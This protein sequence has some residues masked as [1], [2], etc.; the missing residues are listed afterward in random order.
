MYALGLTGVIGGSYV[1]AGGAFALDDLMPIAVQ[2]SWWWT[3]VLNV[4]APFSAGISIGLTLAKVLV[5]REEFNGAFRGHL[6]RT[7]SWYL[8]AVCP[9]TWSTSIGTMPTSAYGLR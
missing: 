3:Y 1:A 2:R 5:R 4:A 8:F 9:A 6:G 7:I